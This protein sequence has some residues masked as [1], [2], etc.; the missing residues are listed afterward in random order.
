MYIRAVRFVAPIFDCNFPG[1]LSACPV[2]RGI[3]LPSCHGHHPPV[4]SEIRPP[5]RKGSSTVCGGVSLMA[6]V[7]VLLPRRA[8]FTSAA[9]LFNDSFYAAPRRGTLLARACGGGGPRGV[10]AA[11]SISDERSY[12]MR[13][14][15]VIANNYLIPV[16]RVAPTKPPPPGRLLRVCSLVNHRRAFVRPSGPRASRC[17]PQTR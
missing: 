1:T 11:G 14:L 8:L 7:R 6:N 2:M 17:C 3:K 13:R 4:S 16:A 10:N 15:C 9:P 5:S 12:V